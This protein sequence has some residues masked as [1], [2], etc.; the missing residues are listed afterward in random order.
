MKKIETLNKA[1]EVECRK[2]KREAAIRE[3][4]S[5]STKPD[6]NTRSRNSL[7]RS[8]FPL[9]FLLFLCRDQITDPVY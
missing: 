6:D 1:I 3:K 8:P 9:F 2:M 7:T 4:D 5:V